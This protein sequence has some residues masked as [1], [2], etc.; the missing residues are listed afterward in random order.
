MEEIPREELLKNV[1]SAFR[2]VIIAAK[3]ARQL[4]EGARP[5]VEKKAPQ[6]TVTALREIAE[7]KVRWKPKGDDDG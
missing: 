7:G 5:L 4:N 1:D 2:L 3:R 6:A